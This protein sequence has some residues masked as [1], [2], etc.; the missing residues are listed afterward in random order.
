MWCPASK[1]RASEASLSLAAILRAVVEV[2]QECGVPYMLTGSL[3]G[4]YYALPRSTQD[5][6]TISPH[7]PQ[8][9]AGLC[10]RV[11]CPACDGAPATA[12]SLRAEAV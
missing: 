1:R 9:P 6:L 8:V 12:L 11:R 2:L 7:G 4:A 3:D 5:M 10:F